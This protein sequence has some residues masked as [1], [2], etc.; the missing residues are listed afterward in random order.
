MSAEEVA[1]YYSTDTEYGLAEEEARARLEAHGEN[2]IFKIP[3]G[4]FADHLRRLSVN[5]IVV[6]LIIVSA[7]GAVLGSA[8]TLAVCTV[9]TALVYAL[10]KKGKVVHFGSGLDATT[11]LHVLED[12]FDLPGVGDTLCRIRENGIDRT[13]AMPR[14]LPG[15]RDF[16]QGS[17]ST[18]K[19]FRAAV[20]KGLTIRKAKLGNGEIMVMDLEELDKIGSELVQQDPFIMLCDAPECLSCQRLRKKYTQ[21]K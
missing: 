12:R 2:E 9:C 5:P 17:E 7:L 18:I 19:F 20:K 13:I 4:S 3:H 6:L 8:A 1:Q 15:H 16:Y 10:G 21:Q 14:N 11:F